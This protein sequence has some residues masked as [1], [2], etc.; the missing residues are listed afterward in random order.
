M[1]LAGITPS[2]LFAKLDA[3]VC[4]RVSEMNNKGRSLTSSSTIYSHMQR[5]GHFEHGRVSRS[6]QEASS[7]ESLARQ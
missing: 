5:D 1:T 3:R 7:T 2:Y 4:H 6:R